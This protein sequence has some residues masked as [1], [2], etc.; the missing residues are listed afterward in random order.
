MNALKIIL[1]ALI[2]WPLS[3]AVVANTQDPDQQER[4]E[5]ALQAA[6]LKDFERAYDLSV[7][8]VKSNM[9][10]YEA[11]VLRISLAT[12]LKKTGPDDPKNL[13][14]VMK[15]GAP[16]GSK[17][18]SDVQEMINRLTGTP[19]VA[20]RQPVSVS[21]YVHRKL[22]LVIGV[23]K[24]KDGQIN[25]L[26]FTTNDAQAF[27][28]TLQTECKFDSVEMLLDEKATLYNIKTAMNNLAG[29]ATAE[30]LVVVYIASH[31][32]P[33]S[34]DSG[35]I[36]Y[37]VTHD[38]EADNLYATAYQ[39]VD[40]LN[41]I[42]RRISAERVVA[43][44]DTC[45]S[46]ATFKERPKVWVGSRDFGIPLGPN[47]DAIKRRLVRA[48]REVRIAP[49]PSAARRKLQGIGRV[50]VASSGQDQQAW[51]SKRLGHGYFTYYLIDALSQQ[52]EVSVQDLFDHLSKEVP[53]AVWQNINKRQNPTMVATVDSPIEIY[54]KYETESAPQAPSNRKNK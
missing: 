23:G 32:S 22:A 51:E 27:A 29:I 6:E 40:L 50:I 31:G 3:L 53:K 33:E 52:K 37:I 5:R 9:L 45:Y 42:E 24:F 2:L 12:L 8:L 47:A 46:G 21:P 18:E 7:K 13:L 16:I 20:A 17:P 43:F 41:D 36:N 26:N 38:T 19:T 48:E 34:L 49:A 14:D 1:V 54:L 4:Y 35:G 11:N 15:K 25:P 10:F 44:I 28:K 39:M 30:D